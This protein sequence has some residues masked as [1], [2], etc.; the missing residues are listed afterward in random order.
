MTGPAHVAAQHDA[1]LVVTGGGYILRVQQVQRFQPA[2][3][4]GFIACSG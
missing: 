3:I 1:G 4:Q 2:S